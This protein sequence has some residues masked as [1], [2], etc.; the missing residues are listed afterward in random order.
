MSDLLMVDAALFQLRAANVEEPQFK[1]G[2]TVL[3]NAV[4]AAREG[5]LNAARMNDIEFALNDLAG[6]VEFLSEDE[7]ALVNE[8]LSMLRNDIARLRETTALAPELLAKIEALRAKLKERRAAVERQTYREGGSDEAL[9]HSP[10]ELKEEAVPIRREVNAA[11]FETPALD[12]LIEDPSSLRFHSIG[13]ILDE[14]EVIA[15]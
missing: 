2:L 12:A 3:E 10:E 11:G 8:P 14:L 15:G 9:P 4:T 6:A 13:A 1:L 7:A 5:G